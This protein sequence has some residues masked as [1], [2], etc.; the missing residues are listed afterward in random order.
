MTSKFLCSVLI[1]PCV[2]LLHL[3]GCPFLVSYAIAGHL[4]SFIFELKLDFLL[5]QLC[6]CLVDMYAGLHVVDSHSELLQVVLRVPINIVLQIFTVLVQ[7]SLLVS[8]PL[9]VLD[10]VRSLLM[11]ILKLLIPVIRRLVFSTDLFSELHDIL[12]HLVF[13]LGYT[14]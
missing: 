14:S 8:A 3:F 6:T 13:H 5:H 10:F 2:F 4:L 1:L 12:L 11:H 7:M 9:S